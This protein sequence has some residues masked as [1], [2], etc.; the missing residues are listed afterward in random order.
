MIAIVKYNAGNTRS[1]QNALNRLGYD[2]MVTNDIE[3]LV[4]ADKVIL[5]EKRARR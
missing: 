5:L 2:S 4:N 3:T 1:V